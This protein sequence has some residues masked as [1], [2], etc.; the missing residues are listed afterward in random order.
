M[1]EEKLLKCYAEETAS[2]VMVLVTKYCNG[3]LIDHPS[4]RQHD[5]L[6]MEVDSGGSSVSQNKLPQLILGYIYILKY[7]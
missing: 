6:M 2:R 7:F 3:C 5:C 4:Q 1:I